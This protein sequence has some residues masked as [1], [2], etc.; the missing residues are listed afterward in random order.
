MRLAVLSVLLGASPAFAHKLTA[1]VTPLPP[2]RLR[3][4]AGYDDGT[5]ADGAVAVLRAGEVEVGRAT[6][7]ANGTAELPQPVG[8]WLLVVDDGA[9]HRTTVKGSAGSAVETG[10]PSRWVMTGLGL[11]V[12]VGWAVWRRRAHG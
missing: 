7:D 8:D 1:T 3:V 4:V 11:A 10:A 9:G 5:P 12:I 2:D 6:L